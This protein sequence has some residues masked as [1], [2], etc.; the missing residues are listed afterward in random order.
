MIRLIEGSHL[1]ATNKRHLGQ[2]IAANMAQG[3]SGPLSYAIEPLPDHAGHW[4]YR[5]AKRERDDWNRPVTRTCRG[6]LEHRP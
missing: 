4:R 1:T 2:M 6:I 3:V 5:I